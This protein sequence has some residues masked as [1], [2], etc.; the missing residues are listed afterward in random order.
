MQKYWEVLLR[1]GNGGIMQELI[2]QYKE[3]I[4]GLAAIVST[5]ALTISAFAAGRNIVEIFFLKVLFR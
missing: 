1:A 4:T 2:E 5:A 3:V